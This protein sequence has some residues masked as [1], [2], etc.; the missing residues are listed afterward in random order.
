MIGICPN[1]KIK[2]K[3]PPFNE[4][5]TNEV[6]L[7]LRYRQLIENKANLKSINEIGYCELC[8]ANEDDF[9]QQNNICP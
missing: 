4:R 2:L 7:T 1:C 5:E 3:E 6:V 8:N 9:K